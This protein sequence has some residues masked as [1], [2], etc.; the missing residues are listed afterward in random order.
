V[1]HQLNAIQYAQPYTSTS[2]TTQKEHPVQPSV[3]ILLRCHNTRSF[4]TCIH[5]KPYE[6]KQQVVSSVALRGMCRKGRC[7][8]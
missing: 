4:V 5:F 8:G 6:I 7:S 1:S 3:T 2:S